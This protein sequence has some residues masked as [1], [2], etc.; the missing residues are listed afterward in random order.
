MPHLAPL[1]LQRAPFLPLALTRGVL[2]TCKFLPESL[3][4][5]DGVA[6]IWC[7][8]GLLESKASEAVTRALGNGVTVRNW[9][10]VTKLLAL[11]D[12]P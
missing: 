11:V 7:P 9:A 3:V 2:A 5:G 8:N 6:Y 12:G 10:T 4:V 1:C